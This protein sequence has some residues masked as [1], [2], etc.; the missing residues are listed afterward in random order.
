MTTINYSL[1]EV[2]LIYKS[3]VKA[4]DRPKIENSENAYKIL[5][6]NW[7][8]GKIDFVEQ[9]KVLLL[10]RANQ[11]LGIYP[12]STGGVTGTIADPKLIFVAALK[13]NATAIIICHNHPSGNLK[14]ST[15]DEELTR[16]IKEAGKFLDINVLD[17]V[18]VSGDGYYSFADEGI[19]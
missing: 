19:L 18:I 14:P 8:A 4:A 13:A 3:T 11:V 17:H 12:V 1:S 10:N 9:F 7:D 6:H 5:L 2:D 15:A 16:K